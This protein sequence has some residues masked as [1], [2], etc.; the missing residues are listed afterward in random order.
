[1]DVLWQ[2]LII[3][4]TLG[5]QLDSF[6]RFEKMMQTPTRTVTHK[7]YLLAKLRP[8]LTRN[9]ALAV[10]KSKILSYIDYSSIFHFSVN[11]V[12]KSK[13]QVLQNHAIRLI[14]KLPRRTNVDPEHTR[15]ALRHTET[16]RNY[17]L[18][19]LMHFLI[20]KPHLSLADNR[21]LQTRSHAG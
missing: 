14:L 2:L 9:A 5:Y 3:I 7:L 11:S 15:L 17:F 19:K 16:R 21:G 8:L 10:F 12:Y 4:S 20:N 18:L 13:L 6:L 1:M